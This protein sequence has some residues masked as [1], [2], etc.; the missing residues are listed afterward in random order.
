MAKCLNSIISKYIHTDQSGFVPSRQIVDN[1]QKSVNIINYCS[2][3]KNAEKAFDLLETKYL[4]ILLQKMNFGP[5]FLWAIKALYTALKAHLF[6]NNLRLEDFILT[7]GTQW[8]CSLSPILFALSELLADAISCNPKIT[9]VQIG[10]QMYKF[11]LFADDTIIYITNPVQSLSPLLDVFNKFSLVSGYAINH[12]KT[13]LYPI[14][15]SHVMYTEI[16]LKFSFKGVTNVWCHLGVLIP[17]WLTDLFLANFN[18]L[19]TTIRSTLREWPFN[20]LN[21][22][23]RW[24]LVE[25]IILPQF[26]LF[27]SNTS[28]RDSI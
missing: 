17:L 7:R 13:E 21:W 23:K 28:D 25:A 12:T 9:G 5:C 11:N 2:L 24:E 8:G 20:F 3:H 27:I 1:F 14:Y 4:Q 16:H 22:L 15:I 18:P 19:L 26:M 10:K 6:L